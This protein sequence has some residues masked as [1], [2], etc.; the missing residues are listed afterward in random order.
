MLAGPADFVAEARVWQH[1]HGGRPFTIAPYALSA[2]RGFERNLPNMRAFHDRAVAIA[3]A[4]QRIDGVD[5]VPD[6]P[7][8]NTFHVF[9]RGERETL[10]ARAHAYAR[11]RG[12]FVFGKLAPTVVPSVQ[13]WEFAVG[14][15]TMA[16]VVDDV[17]EAVA[18]VMRSE[19]AVATA[20]VE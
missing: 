6:P 5:V 1:R 4:L 3:R 12:T 14:D 17:V 13:K 9:L 20:D 16:L 7:Q 8:T 10:E 15:A 2:M 11:E 18:A 19:A